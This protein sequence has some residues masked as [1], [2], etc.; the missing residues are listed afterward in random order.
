[1]GDSV[2][3]VWHAWTQ[4]DHQEKWRSGPLRLLPVYLSPGTSTPH[5]TENRKMSWSGRP[6]LLVLTRVKKVGS[7]EQAICGL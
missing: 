7:P 3:A 5:P 6:A 4:Q 2:G 1:M